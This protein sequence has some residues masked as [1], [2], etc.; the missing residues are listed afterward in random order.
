MSSVKVSVVLAGVR[1][2]NHRFWTYR[3]FSSRF[4]TSELMH[5]AENAHRHFRL[6]A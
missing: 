1:L 2:Q 5:D 3:L 4:L 6:V